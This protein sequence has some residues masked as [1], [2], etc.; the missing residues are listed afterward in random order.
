MSG[1]SYV[2]SVVVLD[3]AVEGIRKEKVLRRPPSVS[4]VVVSPAEFW[5]LLIGIA[6]GSLVSKTPLGQLAE[7]SRVEVEEHLRNLSLEQLQR[8]AFFTVDNYRGGAGAFP[9]IG[10]HFEE[11]GHVFSVEEVASSLFDE[12][13]TA[14]AWER[15]QY[16]KRL[17][18]ENPK[19]RV[20]FGD[21][22]VRVEEYLEST[23]LNHCVSLDLPERELDYPEFALRDFPVEALSV[24][25]DSC[26]ERERKAVRRRSERS[27][28]KERSGYPRKVESVEN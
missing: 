6:Q 16:L 13:M 3:N 12:L 26:E 4:F 22:W 15:V 17:C 24:W 23:G 9:E 7:V 18:Y 8:L 1:V 28:V 5:S 25:E 10:L 2:S 21:R 14:V 11:N 19:A 27:R 20:W